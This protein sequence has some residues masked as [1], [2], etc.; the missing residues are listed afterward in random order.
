M[1]RAEEMSRGE[2]ML[3]QPVHRVIPRLAVPTVISMLITSIYN[4]ADTYFVGQISIGGDGTAA[5]AAVGVLFSAMAMIQAI[6]FTIGMGCGANMSR[7]MGARNLDEAR[8][9]MSLGFFTAVVCGVVI[10]GAGLLMM[11]DLVRLLGAT[12]TILP[13]ARAYATYIFYA[14]P[15]M[16][17]SLVL[18]NLLRF[19]GHSFYGMVGMAT[20][21][22]LNMALDPLLIFGLNL[23]TAG[24]AIATAISQLVSFC[25]LL[26]MTNLRGDALHVSLHWFRP[27]VKLYGRMLYNGMPSLGRQGIAAIS[28]ALLNNTA[29]AWGDPAIAAMSIVG[30]FIFF[31]NSS[32][33]G[34]GQGFQPVC[35]YCYGAGRYSRVREAYRFCVWVST[36][37][38]VVLGVGS[39]LVAEPIVTLFRREDA[40]VIA[41]GTRA[42]QLQLLTIPLWGFITMS[43]MFT[44]SIGYGVRA[45]IIAS[46]RQ[47]IFLIPMLLILPPLLGLTGLQLAQPAADLLTFVLSLAVV[48]GIL[49]QM[50]QMPDKAS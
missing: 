14:T 19:Q 49:R 47:G 35:A 6:A 22:L 36:A 32:V 25:I 43:N 1:S 3:H 45:T 38:L 42:L 5:A 21:G 11:D 41:I 23:G 48:G 28:T 29:A 4:M 12:E 39:F 17:G 10:G 15:F 18:N 7:A 27:S 46:A 50:K 33:I 2:M 20:G 24:A 34:F 44:Q 13:Y 30:R 26:A 31:I 37:I 40:E 8:T 9:F 16:M